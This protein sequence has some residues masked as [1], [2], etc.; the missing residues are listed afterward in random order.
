MHNHMPAKPPYV[1]RLRF[2]FVGTLP[3]ATLPRP[4]THVCTKVPGGNWEPPNF[5]VRCAVWWYDTVKLGLPV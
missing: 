3:I 1:M 4:S 5:S 2:H